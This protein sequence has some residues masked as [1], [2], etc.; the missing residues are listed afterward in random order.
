MPGSKLI[1]TLLAK[2]GIGDQEYRRL[3]HDRFGAAS[4]KDLTEPDRRMLAA[5]LRG[6]SDRSDR[7]DAVNLTATSRMIWRL[8]YELQEFI[9]RR[10]GGYLAGFVIKVCGDS[11]EREIRAGAR[12]N[13]DKLTPQQAYK[14]IE[15]LKERLKWQQD[16]ADADD[17]PARKTR[18]SEEEEEELDTQSAVLF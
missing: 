15:A 6:M 5:I 18:T 14:A 1:H 3:L 9:G 17:R 16:R 11:C 4:S 10:N 8:F 12:L 13:L 7:L 2:T